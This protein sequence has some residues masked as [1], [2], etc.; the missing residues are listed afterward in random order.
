MQLVV[1]EGDVGED[2]AVLFGFAVGFVDV[3]EEAEFGFE[4]EGAGEEGFG[5]G[6]D[7]GGGGDFV[8]DAEGRGV[9]DEDVDTGWD[10]FVEFGKAGVGE[11][12]GAPEGELPRCAVDSEAH[13]GDRGVLEVVPAEIFWDEFGRALEDLVVIAGDGDDFFCWNFV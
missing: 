9:A 12:E 10:F 4:G 13:E 2:D 11:V 5:A 8:V 3:A 7:W 6:V 1:D